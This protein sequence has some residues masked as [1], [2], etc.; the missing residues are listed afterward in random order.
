MTASGRAPAPL[1]W[2]RLFVVTAARGLMAIILGLALWAVGPALLGW[3]LTTVV[4][5]S[6]RPAIAAGDVIAAR[7]VDAER[8]QPG[9]VLLFPDPDHAS[10][11]RL[12]RYERSSDAGA[13]ITK[14]DANPQVDSS[15]ID[16]ADVRGV[17]VLRVPLFGLP[18]V[19]AETRQWGPLLATTGVVVAGLALAVRPAIDRREARADAGGRSGPGRADAPGRPDGPVPSQ[20]LLRSHARGPAGVRRRRRARR[21]GSGVVAI[22]A[23]ASI[24]L[25]LTAQLSVA[26]AAFAASTARSATFTAAVAEPPQHLQ[27]KT[28]ADGTATVSWEYPEKAEGFTVRVDGRP[29]ASLGA[30]ARSATISL[31]S[32]FSWSRQK[33]SIRSEIGGTWQA[34]SGTVTVSV[35]SFL[36]FGAV[37]CV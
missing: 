9:Q 2:T 3:Q 8:L 22:V 23:L 6:M 35:F 13:I 15:Q 33:V 37:R 7:P 17:G 28:G 19:W 1:A 29:A 32:L 5:D 31:S 14:G 21:R 10:R 16:G 4:S 18:V 26:H 20:H 30:E 12:H 34:T 25:A 24:G 27:C 36:G 11:L